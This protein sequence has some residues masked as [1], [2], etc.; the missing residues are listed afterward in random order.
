MA[1]ERTVVVFGAGAVGCYL[2]GRLALGSEH[3]AVTLIGR[4]ATRDAIDA[5]GLVIV[6]GEQLPRP[7]VRVLID[8]EPFSADL[9]LLTVRTH[10]VAAAIPAVKHLLKPDGV[11]VGFQNGL[12]S[13]ELLAAALG[14]DRVAA[15]TL[16]VAVR[17]STPGTVTRVGDSGGIALAPLTGELPA[18][19]PALLATTGLP[20][21]CLAD[22]RSL[23]WSKL[24]LNMLGAASSAILDVDMRTVVGNPRVFAVERTA[25]LEAARV[26]RALG[27]RPQALPGYPVPL[28]YQLMRLPPLLPR[29]VL[30]PRLARSRGGGSPMMRSELARGR[31]EVAAMHGAVATAAATVGVRAPVN[32]ALASLVE[33]LAAH[34]EERGVYRENPDALL[35]YIADRGAPV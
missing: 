24:L 34:P 8:G 12:G 11:V 31:T 13:D 18:W 2:G 14:A 20:L 6:E 33:R 25:F 9:V 35:R 32:K 27:V 4:A 30:G 21:D 10:D 22:Y 3:A 5:Q 16:T 23:R 19:L 1:H 17:S 15:G 29:L 7:P 28:V 26:M